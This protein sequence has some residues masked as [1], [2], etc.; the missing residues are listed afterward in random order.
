[1]SS[2]LYLE[3]VCV[4]SHIIFC[5][6]ARFIWCAISVLPKDVLRHYAVDLEIGLSDRRVREQRERFGSNVLSAAISYTS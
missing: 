2:A 5:E 4:V 6:C 3:E 1:M